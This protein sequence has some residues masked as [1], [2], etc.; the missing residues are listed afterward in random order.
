MK[1]VFVLLLFQLVSSRRETWTASKSSSDASLSFLVLG[2]WGGQPQYPYTTEA[3]VELASVMAD[4][5]TSINSQFTLA[6]GD[7]FYDT[8]V[9]NVDDERFSE[10]F[11][12]KND[13]V[14]NY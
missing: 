11:E 1:V 2:D 7:N 5:A 3:E 13:Q 10:T 12:V 6:L 9:R 14:S 8:G 4:T